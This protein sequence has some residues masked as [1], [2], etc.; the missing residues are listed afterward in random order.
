MLESRYE[1]TGAL[2][3]LEE[4][5]EVAKQAIALPP[6]DDPDRATRLNNLGNMLESRYEQAGTISDL[7]EAIEVA[8]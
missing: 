6:T 5:I 3:D 2:P 8:R 1:R 7:E 4:A